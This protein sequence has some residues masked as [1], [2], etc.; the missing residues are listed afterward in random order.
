MFRPALCIFELCLSLPHNGISLVDVGANASRS[1]N[2]DPHRARQREG[3]VRL[4]ARC[5]TRRS[6]I[7]RNVN[8]RV[9]FRNRRLV[10]VLRRTNLRLG[11]LYI[12]T[13]LHGMLDR[14]IDIRQRDLV[15]RDRIGQRE[16]LRERQADQPRQRNLLLL[17]IIAQRRQPLLLILQLHLA[18]IHIDTRV[19]PAAIAVDGLLVDG[20][21]CFNLRLLRLNSGSRRDDL[22]IRPRHSERHQV[23]TVAR[24]QLCRARCIDGGPPVMQRGQAEALRKSGSGIESIEWA[25]HSGDAEAGHGDAKSLRREV[26]LLHGF[27]NAR[28]DVGEHL[29]ER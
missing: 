26:D 23:A 10:R 3:A 12:R 19:Q 1:E 5:H 18:A 2:R 6:V 21:R 20:L 7:G 14:V 8:R 17:E 15:R 13:I 11:G 4:I 16:R 28:R 22:Q 24:R 29:R 25:N 9:G 27:A